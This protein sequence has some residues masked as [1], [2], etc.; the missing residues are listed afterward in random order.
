MS[1]SASSLA[2]SA[3]PASVAISQP[4]RI[5]QQRGRHA[6]RLAG[7]LQVLEHLGR[8]VGEIA[9]P[10]DA[11]LLQP[12][13]RFLQIAGVDVDRD[14]RELRPAE[15]G[16]QRVERRHLLA[17]RHAPGGPEVEQHGLAA[18]VG[19]RL[20]RSVFVVESQIGRAFWRLRHA[21]APPPRR[22]SGARSV[23]RF[24]APGGI[25]APPPHCLQG[26]RSRISLPAPQRRRRNRPP[27]QWRAVSWRW[28]GGLRGFDAGSVMIG[29]V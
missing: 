7:F 2:H 3:G 11:D 21:S 25:P 19:Q 20:A 14:H 24:P 10:R 13:L 16:L 5:D 15:L 12:R 26:G 6:E 18:P 8:R 22:G 27:G 29:A 4:L 23:S 9:E 28:R 1:L 17:A